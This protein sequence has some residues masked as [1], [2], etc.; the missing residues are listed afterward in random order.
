[1]YSFSIEETLA[2]VFYYYMLLRIIT[3]YFQEKIMKK[4]FY[5]FLRII[6]YFYLLLTLPEKESPGM[7]GDSFLGRFIIG[8]NR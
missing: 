2:M 7:P 8:R 5:V 4:C 6:A 1:M 3:Y